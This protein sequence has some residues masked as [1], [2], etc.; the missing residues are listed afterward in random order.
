MRISASTRVFAVL[1]D[2]V[3]HSLSPRMQQAGFLA[4][5]LDAVYIALP[6]TAVQLPVVVE[7]LVASGGGGNITIPHKHAAAALTGT[8]DERVATLGVANV[9]GSSNGGGIALANTDVDGVLSALDRLE[10]PPTAWY[11]LGTGGSARAVVGAAR[12][13]G[14]RIA[15]RSRAPG[16]A[17]A[18]MAW[19][20]SIGVVAAAVDE[21]E[22]VINAT[23]LGL[24]G[25]DTLP[26]DA[27]QCPA[28]RVALDLT[29]LEHGATRWVEA[30][31]ARGL[32][33]EDGRH[34]LL[35]QGAASWRTWFP[36]VTPPMAVM[37]AALDGRLG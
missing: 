22:V 25:G 12:E 10:A 34:I 26:I 27:A 37:Q 31:R 3:S 30:C 18:F 1:G 6:C 29:Y 36:G 28:L 17:E 14:A 23:P 35:V 13:R 20:A 24:T 15:V 32:R 21:C 16:R 4:A 19:C 11:L 2:P 33:A 8:R 5:G 7:T 9:F